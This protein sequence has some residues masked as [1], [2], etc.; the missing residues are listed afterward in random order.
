MKLRLHKLITAFL[1]GVFFLVGLVCPRAGASVTLL[2]EEPFGTFGA[3]N[4]T[5]HAAVYLSGVCADEPTRLRL[6]R[7]GEQGVVISRYH[8]IAGYDWLAMPLIPYLYAVDDLSDKPEII[9]PAL[10]AQLR[11]SYRRDHLLDLI[12]SKAGG[13]T[14]A[15]E[16]TQLVGSSFD[17]RI[18]GFQVATTREQDARLIARLNDGKNQSHFNLFFRNCAD[19]A[20]SVLRTM[21]PNTIPRNSLADFGLTTPKHL[22]R[23]LVR[24]GEQHPEMDF[25]AFLI[26][27]VEGTTARSHHVDGIA[28]SLVRSKK[29]IVPIALFSPTTAATLLAA[30]VGTGRFTAPKDLPLLPELAAAEP[31][32]TLDPGTI[33]LEQAQDDVASA[34]ALA[35][36]ASVRPVMNVQVLEAS[37]SN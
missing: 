15:G 2:M 14:P 12:P 28:E 34:G 9:T 7:A 4:P 17:R 33:A 31:G 24:V 29:Y 10:A 22:S 21:Y 16:W 32:L 27:Q 36:S 26:P 25:H 8:H 37:G 30:Y 3:F 5:G 13:S 11:D 18:Y 23:S 6:C 19:F 35:C 20:R 1:F